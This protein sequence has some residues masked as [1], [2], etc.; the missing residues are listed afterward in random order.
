ME[1][2]DRNDATSEIRGQMT[3]RELAEHRGEALRHYLRG[4]EYHTRHFR[5]RQ[6]AFNAALRI[7]VIVVLWL[8]VVPT[9][10]GLSASGITVFL[11]VYIA[12]E[13]LHLLEGYHRLKD[14]F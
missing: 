5:F 3:L 6:H 7:L 13:A 14:R 2:S 8:F 12:L 11:G 4:S 1:P 10:L 9:N